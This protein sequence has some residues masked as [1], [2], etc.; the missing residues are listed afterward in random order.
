MSQVFAVTSGKG[1]VGK[2]TVSVGLAYA[3][4]KLNKKVLI[5]DMDEGLRCLD[6]MLGVDKS[7]VFDLSDILMG[8]EI[9]DAVYKVDGA[10]GLYLIPAPAQ[11]GKIDAFAFSV[12]AEN[13]AALYDT[14]IFDFPAGMDFSL[15]G[16]L[17]KETLFLTV[18]V[19]DPVSVR[20]AA[21]VSSRLNEISC[22][23]RL[24]INNF[25]YSL[26]KRNLHRNI[27]DIID[28]SGL[29][30]V[31]VIP[32]SE[33][34]AV[35]S[36]THKI[37]P[38]GKRLFTERQSGFAASIRCF[39]SQK[40]YERILIMTIALIAHDAKK[41]LMVQFCIAY[42]GILS[43][44]NLVATGATGKTVSEATGL[45]IVRFLGGSQGGAQQIASRIG[46]DEIDLLLLF[47]DPL[48]PK[49][50]EPDERALLRLCDVH[51]IPV[52]T[53]IATAEMLI[54]G[55]ERGD[56]DWREILK[57]NK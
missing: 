42:C 32:H 52:A 7:A 3:F 5:V 2:S 13:A 28:G 45:N 40:K 57:N 34:L 29:Q 41:E 56:L 4:L 17:P 24:I 10:N 30:L 49:P 20:D 26:V 19:P 48:N 16:C 36:V 43:R 23:S 53:N 37:K 39:R 54:H 12:F 47:R 46:C 25:T 55:L 18:A 31:G 44:Y 38:R 35:I 22:P 11:I 1:G 9:D 50:N 21:A 27:D 14:V 8:K 15:Y 6:L 33:E 51:N